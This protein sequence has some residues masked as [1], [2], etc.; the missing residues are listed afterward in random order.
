MRSH[1]IYQRERFCVKTIL[2]N[3]LKLQLSVTFLGVPLIFGPPAG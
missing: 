3:L 1:V 2:S